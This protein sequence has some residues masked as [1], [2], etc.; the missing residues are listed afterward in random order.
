MHERV[1]GGGRDVGEG[2]RRK[3]HGRGEEEEG[4]VVTVSHV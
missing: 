3:G 4:D 1:L 2:R